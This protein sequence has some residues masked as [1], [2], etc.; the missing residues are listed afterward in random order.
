MN[1]IPSIKKMV[2]VSM[3]MVE[4]RAKR[5]TDADYEIILDHSSRIPEIT[6]VMK[7]KEDD[8]NFYNS[9]LML[10]GA[11]FLREWEKEDWD[12]DDVSWKLEVGFDFHGLHEGM[13][14]ITKYVVEQLV[15]VILTL[16]D[17]AS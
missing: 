7:A 5:L 17:R 16:T 15:W 13:G 10:W 14:S 11:K 2:K 1:K 9:E 12:T 6:I 8:P 3:E 4:M